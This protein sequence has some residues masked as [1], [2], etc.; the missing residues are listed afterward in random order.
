[1]LLFYVWSLSIELVLFEI[2]LLFFY[3]HLKTTEGTLVNVN[4][5]LS[6]TLT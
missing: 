3:K 5:L 1:M 6:W 4:V 2:L